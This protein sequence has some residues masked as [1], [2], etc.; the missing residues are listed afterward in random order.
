MK[1]FERIGVRGID[2]LA[3]KD[4]E[5]K[6][7]GITTSVHVAR[8][9]ACI[10]ELIAYQRYIEAER[11]TDKNMRKIDQGFYDLEKAYRE[12]C[13]DGTIYVPTAKVDR[14]S[15]VDVFAF[16]SNP[17]HNNQLT[18]FLKPIA[19]KKLNGKELLELATLIPEKD[20]DATQVIAKMV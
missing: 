2:L 9:K 4:G 11:I 13:A 14:W 16:L 1:G 19:N 7:F 3:A 10:A 17:Q 12:K 5:I 15:E 18:A 20:L 8:I 6:E